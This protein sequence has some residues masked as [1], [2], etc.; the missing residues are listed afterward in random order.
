MLTGPSLLCHNTTWCYIY[1]IIIMGDHLIEANHS[2]RS[3]RNVGVAL[4]VWFQKISILLPQKV[5]LFCNP[6]PPSPPSQGNSSLAH[7]FLLKVWLLGPPSPSESPMTFHWWDWSVD[8]FWN[9]TLAAASW[10]SHRVFSAFK[11]VPKEETGNSMQGFHY[12]LV[13]VGSL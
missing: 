13:Q 4:I 11:M 12:I 10:S 1:K 5:F 3:L 8:T 7:T 9:Y 6:L 2:T